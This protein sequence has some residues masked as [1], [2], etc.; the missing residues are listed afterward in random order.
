M[1]KIIK[2]TNNDCKLLIVN[3]LQFINK[4]KLTKINNNCFRRQL[5]HLDLK[6]VSIALLLQ[7]FLSH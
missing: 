1:T 7:K 3:N 4:K 2:L 5:K 6:V